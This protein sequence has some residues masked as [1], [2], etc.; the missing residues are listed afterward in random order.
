MG[1]AGGSILPA[2]G[3]NTRREHEAV[4][5]QTIL[6]GLLQDFDELVARIQGAQ[7]SRTDS[8]EKLADQR[9]ASAGSRRAIWIMCI[10][11]AFVGA[12]AFASWMVQ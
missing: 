6:S 1:L 4:I 11:L 8:A 9:R 2:A 3:S 10:G 12:A 5:D 7:A